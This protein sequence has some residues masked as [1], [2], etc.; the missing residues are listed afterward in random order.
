METAKEIAVLGECI[1]ES[2]WRR[3]SLSHSHGARPASVNAAV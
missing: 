3:S 2:S 1:E